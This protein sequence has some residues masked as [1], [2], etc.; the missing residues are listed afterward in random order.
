MKFLVN[1]L[2]ST[3]G[4]DGRSRGYAFVNMEDSESG[5]RALSGITKTIIDGREIRVEVV[6]GDKG[7]NGGGGGRGRDYGDRRDDYRGGGRDRNDDRGRRDDRR[8]DYRDDRRGN[9]R[10]R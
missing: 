2:F 4:P 9:G 3:V 8:D 10:D 6:S 1:C 7:R 5:E